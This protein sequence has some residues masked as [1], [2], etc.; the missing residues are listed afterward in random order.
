MFH[1]EL[2]DLDNL[3]QELLTSKQQGSSF[4]QFQRL[5][6]WILMEHVTVKQYL[7]QMDIRKLISHTF[8]VTE[9]IKRLRLSHISHQLNPLLLM[10]N[11]CRLQVM[12]F[13][14]VKNMYIKNIAS[15]CEFMQKYVSHLLT[16]ESCCSVVPLFERLHRNIGTKN[17]RYTCVMLI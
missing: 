8:A 14:H 10:Q 9:I 6:M 2:S 4:S 15:S 5:F 11:S 1:M 7:R 16:A 13:T 3:T 17:F 12:G